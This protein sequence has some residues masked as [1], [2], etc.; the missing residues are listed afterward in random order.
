MELERRRILEFLR[1]A[2][3]LCRVIDADVEGSYVEWGAIV[4]S[5]RI[6]IGSFTHLG[7]TRQGKKSQKRTERSAIVDDE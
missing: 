4:S 2:A 6:L 3:E 5:I 7:Y 1:Y